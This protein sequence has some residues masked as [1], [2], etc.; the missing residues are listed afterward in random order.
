MTQVFALV[1]HLFNSCNSPKKT[2]VR[3]N[4]HQYPC[5]QVRRQTL[6]LWTSTT[7]GPCGKVQART[8]V[9][10]CAQTPG[11]KVCAD[12]CGQV[13]AQTFVEICLPDDPAP[14]TTCTIGH[15]YQPDD[16][17][18]HQCLC[19][20][21]EDFS[22]THEYPTAITTL[23]RLDKLREDVCVRWEMKALENPNKPIISY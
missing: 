12:P 23:L 11:G 13:Q 21:T 5:G 19:F 6:D 17:Q 10:K 7:P 20:G 22:D 8:L 15:F 18:V 16:I 2:Y 1:S 14:K 4:S 9:E 3:A